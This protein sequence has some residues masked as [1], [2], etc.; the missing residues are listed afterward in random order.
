MSNYQTIL[1]ETKNNIAL[2]INI[3]IVN[4]KRP[5]SHVHHSLLVFFFIFK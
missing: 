5:T 2:P 4:K 1:L 3:M